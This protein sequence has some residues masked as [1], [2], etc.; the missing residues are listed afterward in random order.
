MLQ[1][2]LMTC[3]LLLSFWVKQPQPNARISRRLFDFVVCFHV[4]RSVWPLTCSLTKHQR[5]VN[6]FFNPCRI[7]KEIIPLVRKTWN[8]FEVAYCWLSTHNASHCH[9]RN[10]FPDWI[11]L[12]LVHDK[13]IL[14][15]TW[16]VW[17][18]VIPLFRVRTHNRSFNMLIKRSK[19]QLINRQN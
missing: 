2:S 13:E 17:R 7:I 16:R 6:H 12:K 1:R 14:V 5:I 11:L 10:S 3:W 15:A 9:N 19:C 4:Y 18:S 8:S